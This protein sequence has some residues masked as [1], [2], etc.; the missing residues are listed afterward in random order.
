M[1]ALETVPGINQV[2]EGHASVP[3]VR[4]MARGRTLFLIDGGR[5]SSER[6]VGPSATFLD[7]VERG[8]HRHRARTRLG[9]VRLRCARRR[10][11]G[12][13]PPR[14]TGQPA[15]RA[16]QRG[17]RHGRPRRPR[18]VRSVE[19]PRAR[20][21][22]DAGARPKRRGLRQPAG[23]GVQLGLGRSGVSRPLHPRG[24]E[25]LPVG[26][27]AERLRAGLRAPAQQFADGAFLLPLGK[28][29]SLHRELRAARRRR[30]PPDR[31]HRLPRIVRA[32]HRSG[33][34]RRPRRPDAASN[35]R[36]SRRTTSMSRAAPIG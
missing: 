21:R 9:R 17:A 12:A 13:H 8:R 10:D 23:R 25:R 3:A 4:G 7:P 31:V 6:R 16:R 2:S 26:G 36:T 22:P 19:G 11:L 28:L 32:A 35:A 33:S 27:V 15:A 34:V 30:V 29:A 24:V 20:R 14:G 18:L 5:V 1:Q